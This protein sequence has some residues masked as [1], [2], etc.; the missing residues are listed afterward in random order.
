MAT[1]TSAP[2]LSTAETCRFASLLQATKLEATTLETQGQQGSVPLAQA[3]EA[4]A[5]AQ[6][7]ADGRPPPSERSVSFA[8]VLGVVV[9]GLC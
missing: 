1:C 8:G 9:T 6:R 4:Y 7:G 5:Q 2:P 3:V